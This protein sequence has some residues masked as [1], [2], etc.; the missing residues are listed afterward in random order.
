MNTDMSTESASPARKFNARPLKLY[1]A[2]IVLPCIAVL[3]LVPLVVDTYWFAN[4]AFFNWVPVRDYPFEVTGV[5]ADVV[6]FG[7][8]SALAGVDSLMV[9]K[10]LG[11]SV[12]N[13]SPIVRNLYMMRDKPLAAYLQHNKPPKLIVIYLAVWQTGIPRE[14][15]STDGLIV[16]MRHDNAADALGWAL[17][18]PVGMLN[19]DIYLANLILGHLRQPVTMAGHNKAW[20]QHGFLPYPGVLPHL[21]ESCVIGPQHQLTRDFGAWPQLMVQRYQTPQ[22]KV[23]LY[24]APA[25]ECKGTRDYQRVAENIQPRPINQWQILDPNLFIVDGADAH[26]EE[27]FVHITTQL[28]IDSLRPL[29]G[30]IRG[31]A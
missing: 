10:Q 6:V 5:D 18:H 8:S 7:D 2:L 26:P 17:R 4:N 9:Q 25:P 1:C 15:A 21:T 28:L 31:P 30:A 12:V 14:E 22:T 20:S 24:L 27:R 23:V 3:F 11:V 16:M 13:L 29:V 19:A